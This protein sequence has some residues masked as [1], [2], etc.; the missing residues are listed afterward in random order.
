MLL[1]CHGL[2]SE[3]ICSIRLKIKKSIKGL[4]FFFLSIF[5]FYSCFVGV[6]KDVT[7]ILGDNHYNLHP[8]SFVFLGLRELTD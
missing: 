1:L 2:V 7:I 8:F 3:F 4:F 5:V 6:L